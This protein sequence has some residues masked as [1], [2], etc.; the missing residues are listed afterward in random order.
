MINFV[1][2]LNSEQLEV[3]HHGDGPC[4][5]LA[6]AGS[7][8][9]RTIVYR[10]AYLLEQ[11]IKPEHILL[12]TF[13]N[14]AAQEM[15]ARIGKL[16]GKNENEPGALPWSG[17]FHHI[18][19]RILKMYAPLLGY[20]N[21]F[22]VLDSDD[23]Q[24]I[25][26]LCS[27]EVRPDSGGKKFPSSHVLSAIIS[28]AQ[29]AE[30]AVED[31]INARFSQWAVFQEEIKQIASEYR[32]RKKEANA[33]DFDDLLANLLV[34]LHDEKVRKK[35]ADQFAYILV[36]EYQDTNRL[37]A[38]IIKEFSST[39]KNIVAVGDDAQSIYSFRAADLQNI[40]NFQND[41]L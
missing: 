34:L 22:T 30:L 33:M 4:L 39:H 24:A 19:Y 27:K 32:R 11:G 7:G 21:N 29:N 38:S 41:Y 40:L 15:K 23:S 16:L 14:K 5:V 35:Y 28:Y 37:Q 17:T 8:K 18:A 31:V 3:V 36:D 10:V 20:G 9:T 13:T 2:E 1:E 25:L 12:V 26:K 6:G